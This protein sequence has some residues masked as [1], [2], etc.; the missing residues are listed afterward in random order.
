[1]PGPTDGVVSGPSVNKTVGGGSPGRAAVLLVA[2]GRKEQAPVGQRAVQADA[3]GRYS[4]SEL[5]RDANL[6]YLT[7][8]RYQNV[9]YPTDQPFQLVDDATHQA[10]IVVYEA[11]TAEGEL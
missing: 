2:F 10:D 7:A 5:D 6:V 4:F 3:D 8:A 9:N 1:S 11:T